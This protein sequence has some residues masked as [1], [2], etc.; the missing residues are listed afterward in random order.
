MEI[1]VMFTLAERIVTWVSKVSI[2]SHSYDFPMLDFSL[3][4]SFARAEFRAQ[5]AGVSSA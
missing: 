3:S 4:K 2:H 1:D 5:L